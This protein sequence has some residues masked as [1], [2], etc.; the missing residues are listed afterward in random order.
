[1]KRSETATLA[2][3]FELKPDQIEVG[4]TVA[5]SGDIGGMTALASY[6]VM[7]IQ[8]PFVVVGWPT[9][10]AR[11]LIDTRKAQLTELSDETV[12]ALEA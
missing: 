9:T 12:K 10:S 1:M 8:L 3:T 11:W 4:M 7:A 5:L 2:N 6:T